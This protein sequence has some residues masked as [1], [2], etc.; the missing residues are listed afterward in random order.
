MTGSGEQPPR[1]IE[2]APLS[3]ADREA[4]IWAEEL[5]R[6]RLSRIRSLG[7]KWSATVATL[8]G[9]LGA[10]SILASDQ[11][12]RA[13]VPVWRVAYGVLAGAALTSAVLA[14]IA[15]AYA[16]QGGIV[17]IPA[18]IVGRRQLQERLVE[19][20]WRHLRRSRFLVIT[21]LVLLA[22][23][24]AIRWYAPP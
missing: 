18:D 4:D 14:T 16:A 24:L 5:T 15:A 7:E 17:R 10:G 1:L 3:P 21:A 12:I 6:E 19:D 20:G 2:P 23:A 11:A 13:L 8:T 9:L 22:T